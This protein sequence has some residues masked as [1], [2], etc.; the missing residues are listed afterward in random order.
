MTG[1]EPPAHP[2]QGVDGD[3]PPPRREQLPLPQR[4]QMSHLEPQLRTPRSPG[5][6]TPFAAF[7][8]RRPG[9]PAPRGN[10]VPRPELRDDHTSPLPVQFPPA[11][12]LEGSRRAAERA[13]APP[14]PPGRRP[15]RPHLP[16][17]ARPHRPCGRE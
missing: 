7:D 13:P 12:F 11:A 9:G 15:V 4:E 6:G 17:S 3:P 16:P 2:L 8:A 5:E 10:P 14:P 1:E